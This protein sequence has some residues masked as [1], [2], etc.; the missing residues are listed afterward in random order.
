MR[1][2]HV[3]P[4]E[5]YQAF[6]DLGARWMLPCHWGTFRLTDEPIDEPPRELLRVVAKAGGEPETIKVLAIGERWVIGE[7]S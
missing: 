5:A 7:D 1:Y 4:G 2:S 3:N 6:L